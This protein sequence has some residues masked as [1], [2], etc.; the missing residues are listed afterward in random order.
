MQTELN[1]VTLS[2]NSPTPLHRQIEQYLRT[3]IESGLLAP[4]IM[5]PSVKALCKQFGG[6]NHLTVRQA[7]RSLA[8]QGLVESIQGRG[9]FVARPKTQ[10]RRIALIVPFLNAEWGVRIAHG[11]QQ[12]ADGHAVKTLIMDSHENSQEELDNIR[13]LPDLP[14]T[15]AIILPIAYGNLAEQIV[16]L[17]I[18][19]FPIV[20]IDRYF[21][22]VEIPAVVVDNYQ[23]S[24]NLT[25]HLIEKGRKRMAWVGTLD[26]TSTRLR[27]E[28]F[29]DALN[30]HELPCPRSL[31]RTLNLPTPTTAIDGRVREAIDQLLGL[32]PRPDAIVFYNDPAA[33]IGMRELQKQGLRIPQDV[34]VA[35]FDNLPEAARCDPPLT[36]VSQPVERLGEE[37]AR[38]L[39]EPSQPAGPPSKRM[40]LPVELI[41]RASS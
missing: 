6:I 39:L 29:R 3:Q 24:Y 8:A 10:V 26:A 33:I 21:E 20:L 11:V 2:R 22:D 38:L 13:Q 34:A 25:R 35:G 18:D 17:K 36:T 4:G 5:L 19:G 27:W 28:G 41:V 32:T 31:C 15:G 30:D 9:V 37:A 7:I 40:V 23:G 14:L 12:V 16:K 1:H